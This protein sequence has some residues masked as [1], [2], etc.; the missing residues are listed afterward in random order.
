MTEDVTTFST[1]RLKALT[2]GVIAIVITLLVLE[3][4]VPVVSEIPGSQGLWPEL[5]GL[6]RELLGYTVSFF[7][8]GLLWLYH[9]S[10]FRYVRK[11]DGTLLTLNVFFLFAVSI[12]PFSSALVTANPDER[13][14]A[15]IYGSSIFLAAAANAAMFAYAS[16]KHRLVDARLEAEFIRRE[17]VSA[18][19]IL[20]VLAA[21]AGLGYIGSSYTYAVLAVA[22]TYYW[23]MT[24]LN[25]E[26]ASATRRGDHGAR[27]A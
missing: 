26:G 24:A 17:N 19:G 1:D 9:H 23:V 21:G 16:W 11:A 14:A 15:I 8:V 7:V 12:T 6:W 27:E 2:D 13:L 22:V 20:F 5:R 25:R 4:T 3:L 18:L 10:V